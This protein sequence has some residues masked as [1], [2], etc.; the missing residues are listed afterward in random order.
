MAVEVMNK[1][2]NYDATEAS[3][4]EIAENITVEIEE[5]YT[6]E[7]TITDASTSEDELRLML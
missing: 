4:Y 7:I 6:L 3:P 2:F 5:N 1:I